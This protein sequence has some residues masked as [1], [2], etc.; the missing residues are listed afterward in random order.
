MEGTSGVAAALQT[1]EKMAVMET[2]V[3][4]TMSHPNIVQVGKS[5]NDI[6]FD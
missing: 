2:V 5:K 4:V 1:R 6:V 3:S